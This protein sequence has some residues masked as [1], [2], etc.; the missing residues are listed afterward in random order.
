MTRDERD[1]LEVLTVELE[2]LE[3][4]GYR[5]APQAAWRPQFVFQDSPTCLNLDPVQPQESCRNCVLM[6]LI[7]TD[8]RNKAVQCRYI[9][10]SEQEET[11]DF[12]YRTG[13]QE[14]LEAAVAQW[15]KTTIARLKRE[16]KESAKASGRPEVHVRARFVGGH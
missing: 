16:R 12:L 3:K 14:E 15:L 7:P 11:I 5:H 4:G 9:S 8:V 2:F 1:L 13:T 10:L 6:Q